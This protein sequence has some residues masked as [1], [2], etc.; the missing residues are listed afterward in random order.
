MASRPETTRRALQHV[1]WKERE[2]PVRVPRPK[3]KPMPVPTPSVRPPRPIVE[4]PIYRPGVPLDLA[5]PVWAGRLGDDEARQ[6]LD[7]GADADAVEL[8]RRMKALGTAVAVFWHR[9]DDTYECRWV[10]RRGRYGAVSKSARE[11]I[12]LTIRAA[13]IDLLQATRARYRNRE[14]DNH[15]GRE[16]TLEPGA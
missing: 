2:R 9:A 15:D 14:G 1:R 11:A 6:L 8:L 13:L 16:T 10:V 7:P 4:P 5:T 3:A 12:N